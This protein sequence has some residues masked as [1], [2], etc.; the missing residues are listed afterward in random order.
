MNSPPK[1]ILKS[2]AVPT[3]FCFTQERKKINHSLERSKAISKKKV[4]F[5]VQLLRNNVIY[6]LFSN[7]L[8][9]KESGNGFFFII[10]NLAKYLVLEVSFSA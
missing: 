9:E 1:V 10:R 4:I 6:S 2:D 3:I 5:Y 7:I 8:Y